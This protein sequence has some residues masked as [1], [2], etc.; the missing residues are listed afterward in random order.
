MTSA[1]T[2]LPEPVLRV[3]AA[4]RAAGVDVEPRMMDQNT[5]TA[6]M[7]ADAVGCALGAIVKSIIFAHGDQLALVMMAGDR[8]VDTKK[9]AAKL[10]VATIKTADANTIKQRT[11]YVIGGVPPIGHDAM[12]LIF[13]DESLFRF[14]TVWA[15]AGH[16]HAVFPINPSMLAQITR[17]SQAQLAEE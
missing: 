12:G 9:L 8:R 16:Q 7:A 5:R 17:A 13:I 15:A 11:G 4:L 10:G 3:G 1:P 14:E 2:G 6:Q